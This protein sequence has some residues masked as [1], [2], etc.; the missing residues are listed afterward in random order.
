MYDET[1]LLVTADH[2]VSLH[3]GRERR[4]AEWE[5]LHEILW[6]PLFVKAPGQEEGGPDDTNLTAIDVVPTIAAVLGIEIPWEMD[7]LPASDP[8]LKERRTKL[9]TGFHYLTGDTL[10]QKLYEIPPSRVE[11]ARRRLREEV[12]RPTDRSADARWWP[13]LVGPRPDLIGERVGDV[14]IGP[15]SERSAVL[16]RP[17]PG[18]LRRVDVEGGPIPAFLLGAI[19]GVS[20]PMDARV[21]VALNGRIAGV[22]EV[23]SRS[24]DH[25]L[26]SVLVPDF[27]FR[28]V[29]NEL[30][31]F[32]LQG[33]E[34]RPLSMR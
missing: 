13:Y 16:L 24:G 25:G 33:S 18:R 21:A 6:V 9:I 2:G 3:P 4:N 10:S 8:R 22:S 1:L 28:P 32:L 31:L 17:R 5:N 15:L 26:F 27:L 30:E 12:F 34:L 23:F 20:G 19:E 7:G 29:G 14:G 11:A